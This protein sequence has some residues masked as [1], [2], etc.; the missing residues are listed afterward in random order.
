M[1]DLL[2]AQGMQ[3]NQQNTFF[4]DGG[5]TV[6][7]AT[8]YLRPHAE[9]ILDW[10]HLTMRLTVLRQAS[11]LAEDDLTIR[12][13]LGLAMYFNKQY[14]EACDVLSRLV[15]NDKYAKRA[16]LGAATWP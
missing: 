11:I 9:H 12:E 14:R 1:A 16:D 3:A 5:A 4:T 2:T 10:F 13:H 6:E 8:D 15:G 7:E